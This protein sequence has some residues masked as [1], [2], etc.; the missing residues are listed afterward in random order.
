MTAKKQKASRPVD[1]QAKEIIMHQALADEKEVT[2]DA[3]LR[4]DL[5]MDSL[6][7]VEMVMALE[8]QF[9]IAQVPDETAEKFK[10][11]QEVI[12]FVTRAVAMQGAKS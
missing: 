10:T 12:D 1:E 2:P 3:T 5:G 7:L 11:V 8:E 4:D 6:D 9:D